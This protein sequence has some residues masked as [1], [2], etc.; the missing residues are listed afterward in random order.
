[1]A[2]KLQL[3]ANRVNQ[4]NKEGQDIYVTTLKIKYLLDKTY[5]KVNW[6]ERKKMGSKEQGYQRKPTESRRRKIAQYIEKSKNPIFPTNLLIN[7]NTKLNFI[8]QGN[9]D[10]G[11]LELARYP[12]WIVDGQTRIE[13]FRYAVDE[14]KLD[15]IL[16]YDMPVTIL[17]NNPKIDELQQFFI[18][19]STQKRVSTDL[20]QRLKLELA[21]DDPNEYKNLGIGDEWELKAL[22][23]VDLL[24][25]KGE[26]PWNDKVRLPNTQKSPVNIISQNSLVK[27]FR[28]LYRDTGMLKLA[29]IEKP[30]D[31]YEV[32]R[33]YWLALKELFPDAFEVAKDYVIQKTPGVFSLH[34]LANTV[35]A[36]LFSEK[37]DFT[38]DNIKK[39][40][41]IVFE[42]NKYDDYFWQGDNDSVEAATRAGSM[43]G[44]SRLTEEFENNL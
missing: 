2:Q 25:T 20:A 32:I 12:L 7:S 37:K 17:S 33:D 16:E 41:S 21:K 8:S 14:L 23:V 29:G 38:K 5:F 28:P 44:F 24:N 6:W 36:R 4:P 13:G 22:K 27:S 1:M 3:K 31:S 10:F 15:K 40:L 11:T 9:S 30:D 43:K 35:L 34:A 42:D 39:V 26:S 18:L 19:N